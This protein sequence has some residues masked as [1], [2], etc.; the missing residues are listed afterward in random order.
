V[1]R[2]PTRATS[3]PIVEISQRTGI[4]IEACTFIGSSPIRFY[5]EE[6]TLEKLLRMTEEAV[7]LRSARGPAGNVRYPKTPPARIRKPFVRYTL[8]RFAAA[9]GLCAFAILSVTQRPTGRVKWST[10]SKGII[11]EQGEEV[12][13]DWQWPSVIETRRD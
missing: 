5:A 6:W 12:R 1:P 9:L 10:L 3:L 4:T 8:L 13:L 11:E 2:A 7:M